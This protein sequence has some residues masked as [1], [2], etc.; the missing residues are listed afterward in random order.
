V[1]E[2]GQR[3]WGSALGLIVLT[4]FS[5][6]HSAL[7]IFV[8]LALMLIALPPRRPWHAIVGV[9]GAGLLLWGPTGQLTYDFGRGWSLVLAG[10]FL[11]MSVVIR[12]D[13]FLSRALPALAGAVLTTGVFFV[14]NHGSFAQ[15]DSAIRA[16]L[17]ADVDR[18]IAMLSRI[19]R[20]TGP[21]M[22]MALRQPIEVE[23]LLF[24][25][26]LAV[27]SVSGLAVAWWAHRR[28]TLPGRT[29]LGPLREFRFSDGVV[30]LLIAG[31]LLLVLPLDE[32]ARRV[33]SNLLAFTG[34]LY[35]LR[36]LAVAI[37]LLGSPGPLGI[38][39]AI[40]VAVVLFPI[41]MAAA[42]VVGLTDM[43]FDLRTR[44]GGAPPAG[45]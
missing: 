16:T 33:G 35:A 44:W 45:T 38:V 12:R 14:L 11:V 40:V 4:G 41:V 36:G 31:L 20:D 5:V 19:G 21:G 18:M 34:V 42:F 28:V 17:E 1:A 13:R 22:T 32:V 25:A 15:L 7:L 8:P 24:P 37:M 39:A 9:F 3:G 10:W 26:M 43:W 6:V 29:A 2:R 30:W 27:S 23:M